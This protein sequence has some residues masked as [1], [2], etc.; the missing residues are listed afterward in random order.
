MALYYYSAIAPRLLSYDRV[1][2]ELEALEEAYPRYR[3]CP[4]AERERHTAL[5]R[6][7]QRRLAA[8]SRSA[9]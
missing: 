2:C 7:Q 3:D 1:L 4:R 5:L 8:G 9:S 6:E